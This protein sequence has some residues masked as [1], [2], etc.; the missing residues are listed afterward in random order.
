MSENE[1]P[2]KDLSGVPVVLN[3]ALWQRRKGIE[4]SW[5]DPS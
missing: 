3:R 1:Q 4:Y 5:A 2:G